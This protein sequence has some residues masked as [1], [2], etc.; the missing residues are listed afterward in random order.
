M[1]RRA[2]LGYWLAAPH[3]GR[4]LITDAVR[5]MVTLLFREWKL[6]RVEIHVATGNLRSAAIPR[7]LSFREEAVLRQALFAGERF[8]DMLLFAALED[9]W[10]E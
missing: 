2:S 5:A 10:P 9:E 7:R 1:N 6:H 4:G 3:Q 8:H